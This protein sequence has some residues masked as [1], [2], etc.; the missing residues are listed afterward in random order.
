TAFQVG[1]KTLQQDVCLYAAE[2]LI[3]VIAT[4]QH[5]DREIHLMLNQLRRELI[6]HGQ[7]GEPWKARDSFDAIIMIDATA[8][9]VLLAMI[10][11]PPS[12]HGAGLPNTTLRSLTREDVV[13]ISAR[14]ELA[15]ARGFVERLGAI[16]S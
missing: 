16:L 3:D 13:F 6:R 11:E 7:A 2:S 14:P 4:M 9:T 8:G 15:Q 1:W 10:D 12:L 5:P